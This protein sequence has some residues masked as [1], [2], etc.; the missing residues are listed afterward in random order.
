MAHNMSSDYFEKART[1]LSQA[2]ERLN[3]LDYSTCTFR[4]AECIELSLKAALLLLGK[5]PPHK[6]DLS[7][8]L[9]TA[10][11]EL[12]EW[13]RERAPRFALVS[14]ITSFLRTHATY[15]Y[16]AMSASPKKLFTEHEAKACIE[17][18]EEVLEDC[19]RLFHEKQ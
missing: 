3:R 15:G 19:R 16:E 9:G 11:S 5:I 17:D 1:S 6:H 12:P 2:E 8:D 10:Y 4:A 14:R 7:D 13:F 18:A